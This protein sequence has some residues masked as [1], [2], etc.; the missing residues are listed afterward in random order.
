MGQITYVT[1]GTRSGKSEFAEKRIFAS[2]KNKIYIATAI[3][4]DEEMNERA[5]HHQQQRGENWITLEAH[6]NLPHLLE[7]YKNNNNI[8]L[9]DCLTNLVTN[10]M[11]DMCD[12]WD[13]I[14]IKKVVEIEHSIRNEVKYLINFI[15]KSN[16]ELIVVTNELGM[17]LIPATPLGRHFLDICGRINQYVAKKANAAYFIVSG[18][19]IQLK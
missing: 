16:L 1:G 17:G 10:R 8:I 13:S 15:Q 18:L 19:P 11:F 2:Q 7:N 9:L 6:Q 14:K 12:N 3:L 4:F 5:R